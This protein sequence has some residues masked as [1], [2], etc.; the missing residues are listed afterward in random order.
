MYAHFVFVLQEQSLLLLY[1]LQSVFKTNISLPC[2]AQGYTH[3]TN[4][5]Y[6]YGALVFPFY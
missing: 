5:I 4:L 6:I 1:C 3:V 2:M